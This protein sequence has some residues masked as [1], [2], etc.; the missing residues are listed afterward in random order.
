M[1]TANQGAIG[2]RSNGRRLRRRTWRIHSGSPFHHDI[3]STTSSFR[4]FSGL[5]TYST[6]SDQPSL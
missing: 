2:L 5:K 3:W 1:L 4:P 6:S